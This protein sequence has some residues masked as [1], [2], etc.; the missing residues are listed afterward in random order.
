MIYK[1]I[2]IEDDVWKERLIKKWKPILEVVNIDKEYWEDI[3]NYCQNH[4]DEVKEEALFSG[5]HISIK[6]ISKLDLSKVIF[7]DFKEI[8]K[9]VKIFLGISR[10]QLQDVRAQVWNIDIMAMLESSIIEQMSIYLNDMITNEGGLL[11][12]D[13]FKIQMIDD[14]ATPKLEMTGYV[15]SFNVYRMKKLKKVKSIINGKK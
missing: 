7:T 13:S 12:G 3:A 11:I 9:P 14:P 8:C 15:L 6:I 4:Q 1:D 2:F 5:L 10:E